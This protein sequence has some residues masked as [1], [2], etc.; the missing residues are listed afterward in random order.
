MKNYFKT[1]AIMF[2][3]AFAIIL[4]NSKGASAYSM[5]ANSDIYYQ[6]E[7][8]DI[9]YDTNPFMS[10]GKGAW[11]TVV[12]DNTYYIPSLR[13]C[14]YIYNSTGNVKLNVPQKAGLYKI[15][16]YLGKYDENSRDTYMMSDNTIEVSSQNLEISLNKSTNNLN[17]GETDN[18]VATTS[19]SAVK[20]EWKSSDES[21]ATVDSNGKVTAIKKGQATIN[22]KIIGHKKETT[23]IINVT[24]NIFLEM[25]DGNKYSVTN[26][27]AKD[28]IQWYNDRENNKS[29]SQ[30]YK[31]NSSDIK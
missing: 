6:C 24:D 9:S 12:P 8:I 27:Q 31:F 15:R 10:L 19:P 23:C 28:F 21:V 16:I 13:D 1:F 30:T 14:Q 18:L 4:G 20:V 29:K 25:P 11:V 26:S 17:V 2:I 5:H 22:A 3:V 7:T